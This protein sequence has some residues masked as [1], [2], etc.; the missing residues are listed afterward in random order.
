MGDRSSPSAQGIVSF[1]GWGGL[2]LLYLKPEQQG[3]SIGLA[4]PWN[5]T[6]LA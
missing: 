5:S 4:N 6:C 2:P 1:A 3:G